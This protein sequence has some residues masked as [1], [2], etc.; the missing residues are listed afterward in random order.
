VQKAV[1]LHLSSIEYQASNISRTLAQ[2]WHAKHGYKELTL[3]I[4]QR[5]QFIPAMSR[6]G[7]PWPRPGF[8]ELENSP[9]LSRQGGLDIDV[10]ILSYEDM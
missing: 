8:R 6:Q 1:F 10:K 7:G 3:E 2:T 5:P 4:L 9:K